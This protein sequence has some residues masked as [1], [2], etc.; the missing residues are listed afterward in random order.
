MGPGAGDGSRLSNDRRPR[1]AGLCSVS[2]DLPVHTGHT[3][4][5][6]CTRASPVRPVAL[7]AWLLRCPVF[8][9]RHFGTVTVTGP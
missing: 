2:C 9:F 3:R 1:L 4:V 6:E 5:H 7:G 8:M